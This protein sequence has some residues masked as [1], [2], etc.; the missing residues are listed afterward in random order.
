ML[1]EFAKH[2]LAYNGKVFDVK[3]HRIRYVLLRD[4]CVVPQREYA[5]NKLGVLRISS[6]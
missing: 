1:V 5:N 6:T 4:T 2:I 3:A